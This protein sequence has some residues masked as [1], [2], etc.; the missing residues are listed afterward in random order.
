MRRVVTISTFPFLALALFGQPSRIVVDQAQEDLRAGRYAQAEEELSRV[1]A[2]EPSNWN[3][4]CDLGAARIQLGKNDLAINAFEHA[5]RL[6]PQQAS[7]YFGLGLAYMKKG[8]AGKALEAYSHGLAR[9]PNDLAANQNY[10]LLLIQ[11]G[12]FRHAIEP[13]KRLENLQPADVSTRATLIEAYAKTGMKNE[14]VEETGKLLS[15][16]LANMQEELS[17]ARL[18]LSNGEGMAAVKVLQHAAV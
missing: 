3:L 16:N 2:A 5:H 15:A 4:W 12:D 10:A 18:L 14:V 6:S 9:M 1:L 17:L 11:Q 13:L 8:D 7:P